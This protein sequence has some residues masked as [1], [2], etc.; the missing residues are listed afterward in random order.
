MK[1]YRKTYLPETIIYRDTLLVPNAAL[2]SDM[3]LKNMSAEA[4]KRKMETFPLKWVLVEV[5]ANN[6]NGRTDLH[7]QL[8]KPM[9]WIFTE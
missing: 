6:L 1:I 7:G 9:K 3:N 8:Y 2:S 5:L 4:I